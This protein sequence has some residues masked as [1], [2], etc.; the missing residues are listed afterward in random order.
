MDSPLTSLLI[1]KWMKIIHKC[2]SLEYVRSQSKK[3]CHFI[4]PSD[5]HKC[6]T[7][8]RILF[9]LRFYSCWFRVNQTELD[10]DPQEFM[11]D[12]INEKDYDVSIAV[13][14][15]Y[16]PNYSLVQ[17]WNDFFHLRTF[18]FGCMN[19]TESQNTF[20]MY[21]KNELEVD[22]D[23]ISCRM[24]RRHYRDRS[25][26]KDNEIRLDL[27]HTKHEDQTLEVVAQQ[28][29]DMIHCC[30]CHP[31]QLNAYAH[32][33]SLLKR[34]SLDDC[35]QRNKSRKYSKFIA[36]AESSHHHS[37]TPSSTL[38]TPKTKR[39]ILTNARSTMQSFRALP[40]VE[41]P[42]DVY[43]DFMTKNRKTIDAYARCNTF[44]DEML[45]N[46]LATVTQQQWEAVFIKAKVLYSILICIKI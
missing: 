16:L 17:L 22:C 11:V 41:Q 44:R 25:N 24:L 42:L 40:M 31:S 12:E 19:D 39:G 2:P 6:C 13:F 5:I 9:I 46:P 29:L 4:K 36:K 28:I 26:C 1:I 43:D 37:Y 15:S 45:L 32:Q 38:D 33:S 10:F 23:A 8:R 18:H 7:L 14:I 30:T 27:Y 35:H 34:R 21:V 20:D 3:N